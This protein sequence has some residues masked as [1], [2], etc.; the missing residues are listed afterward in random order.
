MISRNLETHE[1]YEVHKLISKELNGS[2]EPLIFE[3]RYQGHL[4]TRN[5]FPYRTPNDH[6]VLWIQPGYEKFYTPER[7]KLIV[8][9]TEDLWENDVQT[10]SVCAPM[11]GKVVEFFGSFEHIS[12]CGP[13]VG[14]TLGFS[15]LFENSNVC[16]PM[17]ANTL[18][19]C[20]I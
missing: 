8:G 17:V 5:R 6:W 10:R 4:L 14:T 2:S 18:G 19:L 11:S 15:G 7:I 9:D 12:V 20:G 3:Q 1:E 13:M 16:G